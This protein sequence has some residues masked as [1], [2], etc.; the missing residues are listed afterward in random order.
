MR[1]SLATAACVLTLL[2]TTRA[3]QPA[4]A[5]APAPAA[6]AAP[7]APDPKLVKQLEALLIAKFSRD[8]ADIFRAFERG[9]GAADIAS[10]TVTDRFLLYFRTGDWGKV[11]E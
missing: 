10:L 5:P 9:G 3:Q 1:L 6:P 7:A 8:P 2:S 11:R 4:A